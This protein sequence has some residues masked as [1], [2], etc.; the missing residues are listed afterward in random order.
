MNVKI[1]PRTLT[2]TIDAMPS[3]SHAHRILIAQK[4]AQMQ[5]AGQVQASGQGPLYIPDFSEDI[6]AT[7]NCLVQLDKAMPFLDCKESGSTLRFLLPVVMALKGEA[8]F[9]GTGKLPYRP[10][11]P[12]KE[13]MENH[14]CLF[15]TDMENQKIS[16]KYK[17]ICTVKGGLRPG[18]YRL[19]GN[20]SSQFI[21]GFLL[22]LPLLEKDST[23]M[24]TTALESEGYVD[25][26]LDVLKRFGIRIEE[27]RSPLGF[28]QY[29][30]PGNQRYVEPDDLKV[31]GDWSN[32]AFWLA[33]GAL[34]G[35]I[36]CRGLSLFSSQ[37]DKDI[38]PILERMGAHLEV[39]E[40]S[41]AENGQM[42]CSLRCSGPQIIGSGTDLAG[43]EYS[44]SSDSGGGA[45][46][47]SGSRG[48]VSTS[49]KGTEVNVSQM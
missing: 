31:E 33:C 23:L 47:G 26:T 21:T 30:I 25:L 19:P 1:I 45:K 24:L 27:K 2:G 38:A 20:I 16:D 41:D 5:A 6:K 17:E 14:G 35:D 7:K 4:L 9:L 11:S 12:L 46:T 13:E 8:V 40:S 22:A 15:F 48:A 36:T 34:G 18:E 28:K 42:L 49:L 37:K 39:T 43:G 29:E 44:S 3:K 10:L 32:S